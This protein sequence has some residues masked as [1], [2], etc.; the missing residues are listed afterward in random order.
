MTFRLTPFLGVLLLS[1]CTPTQQIGR[2]NLLTPD[3]YATISRS[4][5]DK[6]VQIEHLAAD[7][8]SLEM[9]TGLAFTVAVDSARWFDPDTGRPR[10]IPTASLISVTTND[11]LDGA[12][13]GGLIGGGTGTLVG[14][15][16][17]ALMNGVY[18]GEGGGI[19]LLGCLGGG[20]GTLI[21]ALTGSR[22]GSGT[23]YEF[24]PPPQR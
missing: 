22:V 1:G 9:V 17:G 14:G 16:G 6:T 20:A 7:G 19:V 11:R 2:P 24:R 21:G 10:A 4:T 15:V 12:I 8:R 23:R 3:P 18:G 13:E 5:R